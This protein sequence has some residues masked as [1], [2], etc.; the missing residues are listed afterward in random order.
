[1][2]PIHL[3]VSHLDLPNE[4]HGAFVLC[5]ECGAVHRM[6]KSDRAAF[7]DPDGTAH[8]AND[9]QT[10][11][12]HHADHEMSV[13]RRASEVEVHSHARH[14]PMC[15]VS[16]EVADEKGRPYVVSLGRADVESPRHYSARPGRLVPVSESIDVD[17]G[18][19]R[20]VIDEALF[21]HAAPE[22]KLARFVEACRTRIGGL[23]WEGFDPID[24]DR[25]DPNTQLA[26]LPEEVAEALE[27]EAATLFPPSEGKRLAA[28]LRDELRFAIPIVRLRRQY[29][30]ESG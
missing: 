5:Q 21:P 8:P 30:Y 14:D 26:C 6:S 27:G 22:S 1:M 10:F 12:F 19:L 9:L 7:Y 18:L 16:W 24:E 25:E 23:A 2:I 11:L 4:E 29:V 17:A 20:A 15:R 13:L 3:L 28:L